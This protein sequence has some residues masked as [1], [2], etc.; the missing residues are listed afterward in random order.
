MGL[1]DEEVMR[2]VNEVSERARAPVRPL[3]L[4]ALRGVLGRE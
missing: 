2:F 3:D 4:R 1:F